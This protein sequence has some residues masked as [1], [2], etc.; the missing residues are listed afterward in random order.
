M[1]HETIDLYREFSLPREGANGGK[2]TVF[3]RSPN[4]E[5]APKL[6]PAALVIPGGGYNMVSF[7][8]GEPVAIPL[9]SA[10]YAVFVLEYSVRC[11]YPVPLDEALLAMRYIRE[12]AARFGVDKGHVAA[13]GF[14]AGGHLLGLLATATREELHLGSRPD[15]AVF[16]YSVVSTGPFTHEDTAATISGGDEALRAAL[17]VE[18]RVTEDTPPC[19]IWHTMQDGLVPGE[20][21]L[22]LAAA[23][24]KAGVPF[25]LHIFEQGGHGL[26][27]ATVETADYAGAAGDNANVRAWLDL[28]LAWLKLRGFTVV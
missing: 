4:P 3:A 20:N 7:R 28:A 11:A 18:K 23:C 19:F 25:A 14:S 15:A 22:L 9:L 27:T 6:R 1:L 13:F 10:G 2:L 21:S 26:S 16:G 17:S 24:R 5:N 12:N 8:E